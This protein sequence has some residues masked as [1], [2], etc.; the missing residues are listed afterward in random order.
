MKA[1]TSGRSGEVPQRVQL[2]VWGQAGL[3]GLEG[4]GAEAAKHFKSWTK[5]AQR[6]GKVNTHKGARDLRRDEMA[7][8]TWENAIW[9]RHGLLNLLEKRIISG[10]QFRLSDK[11]QSNSESDRPTS[12]SG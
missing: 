11:D 6:E 3:R 8:L 12:E 1:G 7:P 10:F 2:G 5:R 9:I 4:S